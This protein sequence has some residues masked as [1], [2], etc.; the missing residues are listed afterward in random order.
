VHQTL[1]HQ[2]DDVIGRRWQEWMLPEDVPLVLEAMDE[3]RQD[4]KNV[5]VDIRIRQHNGDYVWCEVI[6][7][8]V[9]H[10]HD[11][12]MTLVSIIRNIHKYKLNEFALREREQRLRMITDNM[13]DIVLEIAPDGLIRDI[14]PSCYPIMG[15]KPEELIGHSHIE[16]VHPDDIPVVLSYFA[17]AVEAP[18]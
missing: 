6:L 2:V 1:G 12:Q 7:G 5:K 14:S 16:R 17:E 3:I 18:G 15:Y 10:Q 4:A 11:N 8:M 9:Y 13:L